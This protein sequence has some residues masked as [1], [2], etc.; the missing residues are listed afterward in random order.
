MNGTPRQ[1][2]EQLAKAL[3][4]NLSAGTLQVKMDPEWLSRYKGHP[5][6]DPQQVRADFDALQWTCLHIPGESKMGWLQFSQPES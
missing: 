1:R 5:Y 3:K 2:L 4:A 6:S